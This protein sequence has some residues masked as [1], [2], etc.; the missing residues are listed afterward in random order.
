MYYLSNHVTERDNMK[1]ITAASLAI[2]LLLLGGCGDKVV[3]NVSEQEKNKAA[4]EAAET[5]KTKKTTSAA[6]SGTKTTSKSTGST[7]SKKTT[8]STEKSK[9]TTTTANKKNVPPPSDL[10]LEC[11][12]TLEVYEKIKLSDFITD[13]NVELKDGNTLVST[14]KLG[15]NK[16]K[17]AYIHDG[18]EFTAELKYSVVDTTPPLLINTGWDT[19]H[20]LG[21]D[22]DI[23]EYVGYGDNYDKK[24]VLT[25]T[26]EVDKDKVGLYP[27]SVTVT[28]GSG[29]SSEFDI[30]IQVLSEIPHE[31]DESQRVDFKDFVKKYD[32]DNV[33]FGIDVSTWQ[34]DIDFEAVKNAGCE[35]VIMRIGCWYNTYD[36]VRIDDCYEENI[37]NA[38][39]A[40]LDVGVYLYT[41]DNSAKGIK[42]HAK[43]VADTL[44]GKKLE[45]PVA[46]DWEEWTNFQEFEI[47]LHDLNELFRLFSDEMEKYGYSSML[48]SSRNL[49]RTIWDDKSKSY[50]SVW[51][52]HF[53]D[54]TDY[55]GDYAIWQASC[56]GKIDGIAGD[57]DMNIRYLDRD[58]P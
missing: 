19:R 57:V 34:G 55:E 5:S 44:D 23:E 31:P 29:N 35:F 24:P 56:Y 50:N 3:P 17:V 52:A 49:L 40:G 37:K 12:D 14:D 9:K 36:G 2:A 42:E 38:K 51:L 41:T 21:T 22:F 45:Y 43:W 54:D 20:L 46:F 30:E 25:Y 1:R 8:A 7:I 6:V 10:V 53:V 39:A 33:Q 18:S 32:S 26:G 13:S 4:S 48:Y 15:E 16:I 27:L 28:D 11:R 47:S 58:M